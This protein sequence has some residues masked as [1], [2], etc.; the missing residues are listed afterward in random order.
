MRFNLFGFLGKKKKKEYKAAEP[1]DISLQQQEDAAEVEKIIGDKLYFEKENVDLGNKSARIAYLERLRDTIMEAKRQ[2]N[3]VKFEYGRVTSYLKD[4]QMIDTAP[5]DDAATIHVCAKR[6]L[7]LTEMRKSLKGKRYRITEAQ[8]QALERYEPDVG[9]DIEKLLEY[10]DYQLK[11]HNDL[12][13]LG[14][15]KAFLESE[16]KEINRKQKTLRSISKALAT[17]LTIVAIALAVLVAVWKID[18]TVPFIATAAFAFVVTAIIMSES[19]KNRMEMAIAEKKENKAISLTNRVKIKYVNN[20]RTLEYMNVKY[21]VR[22]A[23]ELDFVYSQYQQ[24]KREWARQREGTIQIEENHDKLIET[25]KK[26]GVRD[27]EI[28][29]VQVKALVDPSEMVEVR[30]DLNLRRQK[31]RDQLDYNT[32]VMTECLNE[33]D[34]IRVKKPEYEKDV[35]RILAQTG[36]LD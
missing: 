24:A 2:C 5:E 19:R 11:I 14:G 30:H 35:E 21:R 31:L 34:R 16:K 13:R 4:I 22:N 17:I 20:V 27:R 33:M 6:I 26:I 10:E 3:D 28:W 7:E 15:E 9:R 8:R 32:G 36:S 29:F 1:E 12:R 23:T 25:L 18:I